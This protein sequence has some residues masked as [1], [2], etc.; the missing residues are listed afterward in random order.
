MRPPSRHKD[1]PQGLELPPDEQDDG[2]MPSVD[3]DSD[4]LDEFEIGI[5]NASKQNPPAGKRHSKKQ[6]SSFEKRGGAVVPSKNNTYPPFVPL[7]DPHTQGLNRDSSDEDEEAQGCD[8]E[9][10]FTDNPTLKDFL[11]LSNG[12]SRFIKATADARRTNNLG[13]GQ[14]APP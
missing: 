3:S 10:L 4:S 11:N 14:K 7:N 6:M 9:L 1:L 13:A 2:E 8:N 5:Q 12:G